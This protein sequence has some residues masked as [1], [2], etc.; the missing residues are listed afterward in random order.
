MQILEQSI[1]ARGTI[2]YLKYN[3]ITFNN[4]INIHSKLNNIGV[5]FYFSLKKYI[6][7][8]YLILG[9]SPT[10]QNWNIT[11]ALYIINGNC[12]IVIANG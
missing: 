3:S 5:N 4:N 12:A 8:V 7:Y 9:F 10:I 1:L 2:K 6:L 11:V